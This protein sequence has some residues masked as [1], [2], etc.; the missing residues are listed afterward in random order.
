MI[1]DG[2]IKIKT[3]SGT[4]HGITHDD[5]RQ[6]LGVSGNTLGQ[7]VGVAPINK[8]AKYKPIKIAGLHFSSQLNSDFTW[9]TKAQIQALG[10]TP[11]WEG[12][13]GQCG[14]TFTTFNS[15]Y[16]SNN[17]FG[18]NSFLRKL[19]DGD[20]AWGYEKPTGGISSYPF[21]WRDFNYYYH[22]APKPVI[23]VGDT[24][25]L[26]GN[27]SLTIQ[28]DE[29][30]GDANSI[31]LSDLTISNSA[32]SGW[33]VGILIYKS[34]SQY[35]FAFSTSTI[36]SNGDLTVSFTNMS[37]YG[38][39]SVTIVPFLSSVRA[40]QGVNPGNGTFLSCDVAPQTATI[41]AAV[42]NDV[43]ID[44]DAYWRDS[45]HVRAHYDV[46][47]TNGLGTSA[48]IASLRIGLYEDNVEIDYTTV[49]T[50]TLAANGE[51]PKSGTLTLNNTTY[52]ANKTYTIKVT[53]TANGASKS[54]SEVIGTPRAY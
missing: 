38:G 35:T 11:W 29:N 30:R 21:R 20:L 27:G 24:L 50:F 2:V 46:K 10:Q 3:V 18:T 6:I 33:Y 7:I 28:L 40:N 12:G 53:F 43:A 54:K 22:A 16:T 13:N 25:R 26:S 32:V 15:L 47:L 8:W 37:A 39:Q 49:S 44:I 23:G 48:T 17:P 42:Q 14:L 36:G 34:D 41:M 51:Y 45:F 31:Q 1:E 52:D 4:T 5:M 19:K 9:K